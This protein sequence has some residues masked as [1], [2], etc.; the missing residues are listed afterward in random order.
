M[1]YRSSVG[2]AGGLGLGGGGGGLGGGA[3]GIGG[4]GGGDGDGGGGLGLG[5]GGGDGGSGGR[6][7]RLSAAQLRGSGTW[8]EPP[9]VYRSTML[10]FSTTSIWSLMAEGED[11]GVRLPQPVFCWP[12]SEKRVKLKLAD[13]YKLNVSERSA[14]STDCEGFDSRAHLPGW[15]G[16]K[17]FWN[18]L[19]VG[20]HTF[21]RFTA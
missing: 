6:G 14:P 10:L 13:M 2:G 21:R 20:S 1:E 18:T 19:T 4:A 16:T 12:S 9:G 8:P 5:G 11:A 7:G 15:P 3:G 17:L